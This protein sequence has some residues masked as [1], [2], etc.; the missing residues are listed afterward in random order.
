MDY[1]I[2]S[3]DTGIILKNIECP[4]SMIDVQYNALTHGHLEGT[5]DKATQKIIDEEVVSKTQIEQTDYLFTKVENT[6]PII[7]NS[8][9]DA[10]LDT[11]LDSYFIG[12]MDIKQWKID[13]YKILRQK[14]YPSFEDF[15]DAYVK[16][17]SQIPEWVKQ[18][19]NQMDRYTENC[20]D[21]KIRFKKE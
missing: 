21:V 2:Y 4:E 18:G 5:F 11:F 13:H 9:T 17:N 1:T 12:R 6:I 3:K 7:N 15:V 16:I 14:H 19:Q 10:E 8:L 20:L